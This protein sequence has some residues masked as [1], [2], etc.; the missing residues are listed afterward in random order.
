[1][2]GKARERI[3]ENFSFAPFHLT[4]RT[5]ERYLEATV[6]IIVA[7][8]VLRQFDRRVFPSLPQNIAARSAF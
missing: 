3:S 8:S 4:R 5:D 7:Q 6:K 2:C 1:M